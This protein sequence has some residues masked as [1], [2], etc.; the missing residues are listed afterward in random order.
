MMSGSGLLQESMAGF[1][2]DAAAVYVDV[3]GS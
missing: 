2:V 1:M 3:L